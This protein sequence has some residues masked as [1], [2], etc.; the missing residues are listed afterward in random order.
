MPRPPRASLENQSMKHHDFPTRRPPWLGEML[1]LPSRRARCRSIGALGRARRL[2]EGWEEGLVWGGTLRAALLEIGPIDFPQ[3]DVPDGRGGGL[4]DAAQLDPGLAGVRGAFR[5][6]KDDPNEG[7]VLEARTSLLLRDCGPRSCSLPPASAPT[8]N[9]P[10][11]GLRA[12]AA[13]G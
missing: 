12:A 5:H 10:P 9:L 4:C 6:R 13:R 3:T 2:Q 11:A 1:L 7:G 8:E